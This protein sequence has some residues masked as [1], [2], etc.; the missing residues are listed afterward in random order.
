[1]LDV[2][3]KFLG[4]GLFYTDQSHGSYG[5]PEFLGWTKNIKKNNILETPTNL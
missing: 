5:F 2:L 3:W 4:S 1:M